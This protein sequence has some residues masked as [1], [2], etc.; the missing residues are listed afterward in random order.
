M[1]KFNLTL[2]EIN[3]PWL[4]NQSI[5]NTIILVLITLVGRF[6]LLRMIKGNGETLSDARRRWISIIQNSTILFAVLGLIFIWS[7][8]LSTF[9]LSLTAFV[10]A[11]VV[12]TKEYI[13]CLVG[14]IYR[15]TSNPF[16]V[17]DWIEI[18]SLRGEV[19]TEGILTTKLQELGSGS[20][21]FQFTGRVLTLPN[22]LLLTQ[23][24]FNEEFRKYALHHKFKVTVESGVNAAQIADTVLPL[25]QN[26]DEKKDKLAEKNWQK[27]R[28]SIQMTLPSRDPN[29][30][31]ETTDV[32]KISFI[33]TVFCSPLDAAAIEDVVTKKILSEVME[34]P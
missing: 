31:I 7:P 22:S 24:V 4:A 9:A 30:A 16:S 20:S 28:K 14:A 12:A 34:A 27:S 17:G 25:L 5:A 13:L 26:R 21:R 1:N 6:L 29:I 3:L 15:A 32:G 2:A 18:Q 33:M 11:L 8:Q 23:T 10:I 19:L